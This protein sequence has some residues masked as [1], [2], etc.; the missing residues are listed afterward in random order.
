MMGAPSLAAAPTH[1][2]HVILEHVKIGPAEASVD[3]LD[4]NAIFG[5]VNSLAL[6][7]DDLSG[8][9]SLEDLT[10]LDLVRHF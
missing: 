8:L 7:G 10:D 9:R 4:H 6:G 1:E 5:E 2:D 3:D